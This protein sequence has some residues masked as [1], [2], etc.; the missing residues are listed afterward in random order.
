M[1]GKSSRKAQTPLQAP[2]PDGPAKGFNPLI[3]GAIVVGLLVVGGFTF[4]RGNDAAE[5]AASAAAAAVSTAPAAASAAQPSAAEATA[6]PDDQ[7]AETAAGAAA[8]LGPH[9]QEH[10]PPLPRGNAPPPRSPEVVTAAYQFAAEHPEILS[11]VPCF[12]GCEHG[13]HRGNEDCFVAARDAKGDVV[14]W[15]EHGIECAVCIDVANRSRQMYASGASVRDIR[16]AIDKEFAP[17]FPSQTPTPKPP[18]QK[19]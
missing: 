6:A 1:P 4:W 19:H 3:L 2:P 12:C 15:D 5:P 11:Y 16:A 13:G 17:K 8:A 18:A 7:A 14:A 9:K 10:L